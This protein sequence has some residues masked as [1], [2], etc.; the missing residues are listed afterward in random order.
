[1]SFST[2]LGNIFGKKRK[3]SSIG[4]K[5]KEEF[6][7]QFSDIKSGDYVIH[8]DH[9]I[10]RYEGLQKLSANNVTGEFIVLEYAGA[11]KLYLPVYR[12]DKLS[13]YVREGHARPK[14]DRLG[15]Q[16]F[17]KKKARIRKDILRMAHELLKT[18]AERK[19]HERERPQVEEQVFQEFCEEFPYE[20]T[21][22]QETAAQDVSEDFDKNYP[23]DRLIC[24]DVGF[25]KTEIALRAAMLA[26]LQGNQVAFDLD[27]QHVVQSLAARAFSVSTEYPT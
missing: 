17:L 3:R 2:R 26:L 10:A 8:D 11:D 25:G 16:V 21:A 6:L 19:L 9:G 18:A 27:L 14:L 13:R 23:I 5:T 1:M 12:L 7:R 22:D 24:G 20:L 15:T 4:K